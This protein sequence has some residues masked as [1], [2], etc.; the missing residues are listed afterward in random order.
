VDTTDRPD[1]CVG[2]SNSKK[3]GTHAK[4][5]R[6]CGTHKSL[7]S[8]GRRPL[9]VSPPLPAEARVLIPTKLASLCRLH[10]SQHLST[11]HVPGL[12]QSVLWPQHP[13]AL[14]FYPQPELLRS[15]RFNL[16][17]LRIQALDTRLIPAL[18]PRFSTPVSVRD[19]LQ[20]RAVIPGPLASSK[21]QAVSSITSIEQL[22]QPGLQ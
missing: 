14:S 18:L 12:L 6:S 7:S 1:P 21:Q 13:S 4:G 19:A 8:L 16:N 17:L 10:F 15:G 9:S 5:L 11:T 20:P 3:T 2:E 22:Y